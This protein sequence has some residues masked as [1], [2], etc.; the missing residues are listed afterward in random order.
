MVINMRSEKEMFDLI[1]NTAK[2]DDRVR[3]FI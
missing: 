2:E 3:A 1:L